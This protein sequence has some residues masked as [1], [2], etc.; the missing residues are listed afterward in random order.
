MSAA[1]D[2]GL[3][4][5]LLRSVTLHD[6]IVHALG[7]TGGMAGPVLPAQRRLSLA[8]DALLTGDE[9]LAARL[10]LREVSR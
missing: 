2:P 10:V 6:R 9:V 5:S 7:S 1:V 3:R 8:L 4:R